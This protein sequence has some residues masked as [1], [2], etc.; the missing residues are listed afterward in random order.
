MTLRFNLIFNLKG[1]PL[2][3]EE[4]AGALAQVGFG[5]CVALL[6]LSLGRLFCFVGSHVGGGKVFRSLMCCTAW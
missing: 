2:T 5:A 6:L 1:Q 3:L 4:H